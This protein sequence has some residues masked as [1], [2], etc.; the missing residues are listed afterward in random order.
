MVVRIKDNHPEFHH[1][2]LK[3]SKR[4]PGSTN[5][6]NLPKK[7]I[8]SWANIRN[9]DSSDGSGSKYKFYCKR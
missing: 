9:P 6:Q 1:K 5:S 7:L 4:K 3:E 8:I 2:I